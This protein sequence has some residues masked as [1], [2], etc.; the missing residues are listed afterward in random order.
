MRAAQELNFTRQCDELQMVEMTLENGEWVVAESGALMYME[1]GIHQ[2]SYHSDSHG[3]IGLID[4]LSNIG[5][6]VA[7]EEKVPMSQFINRDVKPRKIAF[8]APDSGFILPIDLCDYQQLLVCQANTFLCAAKGVSVNRAFQRKYGAGL[9]DDHRFMMECIHGDG[10]VFLRTGGKIV[11]RQLQANELLRVDSR[12]LLAMS[13]HVDYDVQKV[14]DTGSE[15][16]EN[17]S[18]YYVALSG[19]GTVWLQSL[20]Q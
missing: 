14:G 6:V 7:S 15:N 2:E 5:K 3:T 18:V 11:Q 13:G 16:E 1:Q 17:D 12:C 4:R 9:F 19:P 20:K 10:M 8:S